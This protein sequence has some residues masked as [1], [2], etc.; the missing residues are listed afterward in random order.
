MNS[1]IR[2][3]FSL[4]AVLA[5]VGV[6]TLIFLV[7]ITAL[8]SLTEE[9]ASARA[10]VRFA[11]TVLTAEARIAYL[12]TTESIGSTG[13]QLGA[14]RLSPDY[15]VLETSVRTPPGG[16]VRLD[17]R[18]YRLETDHPVTVRLQDQAGLIN[19]ARL[20]F[21]SQARLFRALGVPEARIAALSAR[22]TDYVDTD[23]LST[24]NG[25]ESGYPGGRG[26]PPNRPLRRVSELLSVL[27]MRDVVDG[28]R[29]RALR[30][31]LVVDSTQLGFN[32]NTMTPTTMEILWGLTP[33][34]AERIV[35]VRRDQ[36]FVNTLDFD[37]LSG[38]GPINDGESLYLFPARS[39]VYEIADTRS[40]WVYRGRITLAP[41]DPERPF[42][43]DQIEQTEAPGRAVLQATDAAVFPYS[44]R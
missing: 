1:R 37:A 3:G 25:A 27:G 17:G 39:F 13:F 23:D 33:R 11:Q 30:P 6:V 14:P 19:V 40:P 29:W 4:P 8:A 20:P 42:W 41:F 22:L 38:V 7:A 32:I 26:N 2:A 44:A 9:A 35:E 24:T 18:P 28:P 31:N 36:P 10:R 21:D 15:E 43:V 34:A 5:V 12:A 16:E